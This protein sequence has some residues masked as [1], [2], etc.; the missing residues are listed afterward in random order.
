ME[1]P[2]RSRTAITLGIVGI[3]ASLIVLAMLLPSISRKLH[4]GD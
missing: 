2:R 3:V 1:G 4:S